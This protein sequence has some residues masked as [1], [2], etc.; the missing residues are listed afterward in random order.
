[1]EKRMTGTPDWADEIARNFMF[2]EMRDQADMDE[3]FAAILRKV[4]AAGL[5]EA[6]KEADEYEITIL[7][8]QADLS[9]LENMEMVSSLTSAQLADRY[10]TAAD[11][12]EH[13]P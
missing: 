9:V 12:L 5:R 6:A 10:R 1:M 3:E 13:E 11:K 4:K 7:Q 2:S 8:T